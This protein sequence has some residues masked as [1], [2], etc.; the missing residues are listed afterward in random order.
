MIALISGRSPLTALPVTAV[1]VTPAEISVPQLVMNCLAP[2]ITQWPSRISARVFVAPASEPASGSVRPK[3]HSF[4]PATRSGNHRS[5]CS[6]VPKSWM[7]AA[8]R[9]TAASRVIPTPVSARDISSIARHSDRKSPPAPPYS[10]EKG[11]PNR[12]SSPIWRTMSYPNWW[13]RSSSPAAGATTSRAKS[14]QTSR[15]ACCSA[16]RSKSNPAIVARLDVPARIYDSLRER[17]GRRLVRRRHAH[18]RPAQRARRTECQPGLPHQDLLAR[19][20]DGPL[21]SVAPRVHELPATVRPAGPAFPRA[22]LER[23]HS[24]LPTPRLHRSPQHLA[25]G[26][27]RRSTDR[28]RQPIR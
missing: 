26:A 15:I 13:R 17:H 14:R 1:T 21:P 24:A 22:R 23:A 10:S 7:G 20:P 12:P 6:L 25:I 4:L 28:S 11:N 9:Q 19:P 18:H 2:L 3:A 16:V 27:E 5:F 8:P